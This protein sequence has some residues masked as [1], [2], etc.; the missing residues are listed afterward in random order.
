MYA[1]V[2]S[3]GKQHK[4]S[5]GDVIQLETLPAD[6]GDTY[7]FDKVLLLADGDKIKVGQPYLA[8]AKVAAEIVSFG[9]GKKVEILKFKRRK[10]HMKR[11]GHRQDFV[12]VKITDI[13]AV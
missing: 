2:L 1:V 3:G 6:V 8:D 7:S 11:M 10:H 12:E 4:V 5:V 13:S 9:R